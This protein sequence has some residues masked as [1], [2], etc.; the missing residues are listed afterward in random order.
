MLIHMFNCREIMQTPDELSAFGGSRTAPTSFTG[1]T[2][3]Y[4]ASATAKEHHRR[5][6]EE[7]M[8]SGDTT[9]LPTDF[10]QAEV[11]PSPPPSSLECFFELNTPGEPLTESECTEDL[12][13]LQ[14]EAVNKHFHEEILSK[15]LPSQDPQFY[16]RIYELSVQPLPATF[17]SSVSVKVVIEK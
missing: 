5:T 11:K 9:R 4:L 1:D 8:H 7:E 15:P 3:S 2:A 14:W 12:A 16:S 10:L 6:S 17:L 13:K